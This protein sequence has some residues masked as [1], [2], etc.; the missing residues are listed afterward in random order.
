MKQSRRTVALVAA[1]KL[2]AQRKGK[3]PLLSRYA[4]KR[5]RVAVEA[6]KGPDA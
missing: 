4:I 1:G 2:K 5:G 6:P 3:P